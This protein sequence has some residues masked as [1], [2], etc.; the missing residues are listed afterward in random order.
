[1][2]KK[3]ILP[4]IIILV[5]LLVALIVIIA[6]IVGG[7]RTN[8]TNDVQNV[9]TASPETNNFF[10]PISD[11]QTYYTIKN[12]L[13]NYNA[14]VKQVTGDE[15]LDATRL[16]MTPEEMK[17]TVQ[18]DG[19]TAITGVLDEAYKSEMQ[20]NDNTLIEKQKVFVKKGDYSESIPYNVT[21]SNILIGELKPNVILAV[22]KS[23]ING[24]DFNI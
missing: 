8:D 17:N 4:I 1:M 14:Y 6:T 11:Y 19:L 21:F 3:K 13:S 18:K 10:T 16:N 22:L 20:I 12:I 7:G 5:I 2:D 23:Q 9:V 24:I 15:Y